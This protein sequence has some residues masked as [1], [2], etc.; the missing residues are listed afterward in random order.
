[1]VCVNAAVQHQRESWG[2]LPEQAR[3]M[4]A[5]GVGDDLHNPEIANFK[6]VTERAVN[7]IVTPVL[8]QPFDVG[9]FVNET[10]CRQHPSS[11]QAVPS[12]EMHAKPV[13]LEPGHVDDPAANCDGATPSWPR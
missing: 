12:D 7:H 4:K 9:K 11:D 13:A 8:G 10:G 6:A 1:M 2:E 5:H 3:L